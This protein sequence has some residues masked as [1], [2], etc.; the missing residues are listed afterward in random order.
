[1]VIIANG[2]CS[3]LCTFSSIRALSVFDA[4][5]KA[6][7]KILQKIEVRSASGRWRRTPLRISVWKVIFFSWTLMLIAGKDYV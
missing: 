2:V 7:S 4:D 5:S 6:L 1:M 3:F